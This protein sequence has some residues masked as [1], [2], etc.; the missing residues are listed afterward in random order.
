MKTLI[1]NGS[2]HQNGDTAALLAELKKELGGE[3][4]EIDA[5]RAKIAPCVDCRACWKKPG[6]VIKD[7][8]DQV[9]RAMDDCD[10]VVVASPIYFSMLTGP[11]L[12]LASRLQAIYTAGRFL[13]VNLRGRKKAG[14]VLMAGGGDGSFHKALEMAECM[15]RFMGA[16]SEGYAAALHTDACPAAQDEEALEAVRALARKIRERIEEEK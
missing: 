12:S 7:E 8:M 4:V 6:C 10:A 5:Y 14:G 15:L 1:L 9:Y 2:P 13:K 11:L 16:A 3:F